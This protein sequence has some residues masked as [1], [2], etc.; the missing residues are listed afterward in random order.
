MIFF[1][2]KGHQEDNTNPISEEQENL[3]CVADF[4]LHHGMKVYAYPT[5]LKNCKCLS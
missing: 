2:R 5:Q 3:V 1:L 4:G